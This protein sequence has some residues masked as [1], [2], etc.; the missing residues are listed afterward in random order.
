MTRRALLSPLA[1]AL[2]L[3]ACTPEVCEVENLPFLGQPSTPEELFTLAQYA[4]RNE[5]C[6]SLYGGLSKRTKDE[7]SETKFCLFW[8]SLKL[9]EP[10]PPYKV[11]DIVAQ[12]L[13]LAILPDEQ[14]R[15]FMFV[16]YRQP[17]EAQ[18][19]AQLYI[20]MEKDEQGRDVPKL[21]LQEQVDQNLPFAQR[22]AK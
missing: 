1:L 4:A 5:C 12:G 6:E 14:G 15:Q 10:F 17:G 9:P 20:V 19:I 18:L 3:A 2:T 13:F 7:H 8:E 21:A 11:V 22:P 16:E